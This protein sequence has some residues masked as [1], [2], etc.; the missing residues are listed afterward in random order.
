MNRTIS[1][2]KIS[3]KYKLRQESDQHVPIYLIIWLSLILRYFILHYAL[4]YLAYPF[5]NLCLMHPTGCLV[6]DFYIQRRV[7]RPGP[8]LRSISAVEHN[9]WKRHEF[10]TANNWMLKRMLGLPQI[11]TE[12]DPSVLSQWT[13]HQEALTRA[14]S[15]TRAESP[16]NTKSRH[17]PS[18]VSSLPS[19]VWQK[20]SLS[21]EE[22]AANKVK[23]NLMLNEVS[24]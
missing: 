20:W 24:Q 6:S 12:Q 19:K 4:H 21:P 22:N 11:E 2:K 13:L 10:N 8:V 9:H 1:L 3:L 18:S 14:Q 5:R 15:L 17:R 16:C 23:I 7:W